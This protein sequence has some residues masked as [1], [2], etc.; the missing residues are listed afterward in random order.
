M[1]AQPDTADGQDDQQDGTWS[2]EVSGREVRGGCLNL[3]P[4]WWLRGRLSTGLPEGSTGLSHP[5]I[6]TQP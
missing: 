1:A 6:E 4:G 2:D 5:V 3:G